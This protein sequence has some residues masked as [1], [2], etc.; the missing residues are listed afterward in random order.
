MTKNLKQKYSDSSKP[1]EWAIFENGDLVLTDEQLMMFESGRATS[2]V[3]SDLW[4]SHFSS[5]EQKFILPYAIL[6]DESFGK[7]KYSSE[8]KD[9]IRTALKELEDDLS[10]FK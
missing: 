7:G 1:N 3:P 8:S 2:H 9:I 6:D 4:L 10:C 5:K